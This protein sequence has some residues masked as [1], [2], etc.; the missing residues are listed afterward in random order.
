MLEDNEIREA[1]RV[2]AHLEQ[3]QDLQEG[4]AQEGERPLASPGPGGGGW[5]VETVWR[6]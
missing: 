4:E 2:L 5:W 1:N 6:Q 3:L